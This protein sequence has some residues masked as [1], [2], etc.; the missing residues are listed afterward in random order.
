MEEN[1]YDRASSL[2]SNKTAAMKLMRRRK[3]TSLLGTSYGEQ[4]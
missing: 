3:I 1:V 2:S 4:M